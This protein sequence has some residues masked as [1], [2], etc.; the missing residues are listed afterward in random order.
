MIDCRNE[1]VTVT[2]T[3]SDQ[4]KLLSG[5]DALN[6]SVLILENTPLIM[7]A[8]AAEKVVRQMRDLIAGN[9]F[10]THKLLNEVTR[11]KKAVQNGTN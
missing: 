11:L 9:I 10:A 5:L 2:H 1:A 3:D 8:L 6:N 7:K 4:A